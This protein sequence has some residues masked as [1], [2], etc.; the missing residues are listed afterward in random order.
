MSDK[1]IPK[2]LWFN[3]NRLPV[4]TTPELLS[5]WFANLDLDIPAENIDFT[6]RRDGDMGSTICFPQGLAIRL[7]KWAIQNERYNGCAVNPEY[8]P[9]DANEWW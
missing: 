5:A 2:G 4:G 3:I 1:Q 9:R 8:K 7:L 6:P